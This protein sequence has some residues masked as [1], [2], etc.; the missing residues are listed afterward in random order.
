[1]AFLKKKEV[2][3]KSGLPALPELPELPELPKTSLPKLPEATEQPEQALPT[4]LQTEQKAVK[5]AVDMPNEAPPIIPASASKIPE[6][7]SLPKGVSENVPQELP[8]QFA[9]HRRRRTMEISEPEGMR[10]S[11]T[12]E[13]PKELP[14]SQPPIVAQQTKKIEPVYV[15]IDKF[16]SAVNS[17]ESIKEKV[18]EIQELLRKVKEVKQKEDEELREWERELESVKARLAAIDQNIFS[19][20]D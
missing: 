17:F 14:T 9:Q 10:P 8:E 4:S 15:R 12:A 16:K 20:L 18:V 13:P 6:K 2:K 11:I 1:M 7:M 19:K 3:Q 5:T